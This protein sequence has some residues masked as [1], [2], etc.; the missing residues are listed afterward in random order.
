M[1]Q[2]C[3]DRGFFFMDASE[4]VFVVAGFTDEALSKLH[5]TRLALAKQRG[6]PD[7]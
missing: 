1:M 4:A 2:G 6:Y 3:Y 7:R 5:K